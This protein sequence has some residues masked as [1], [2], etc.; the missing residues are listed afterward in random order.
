MEVLRFFIDDWDE[1]KKR[2]AGERHAGETR[3]HYAQREKRRRRK[4]GSPFLFSQL[5]G[6]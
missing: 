5:I 6:L 4:V 1:Q 2:R 3:G